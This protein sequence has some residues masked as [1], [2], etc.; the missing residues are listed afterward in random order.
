M[1][2][3]GN[4][5]GQRWLAAVGDESAV[6]VIAQVISN[7]KLG[8]ARLHLAGR[9]GHPEM[10]EALLPQLSE[11]DPA[12]ACAAGQAF[13][14]I[15]GI[16][17]PGQRQAAPMSAGASDFERE[18]ADDIWLPDAAAARQHWERNAM[19]WRQGVRMC[20]GCEI[21]ATLDQ[22]AQQRIDLEAFWDFGARAALNGQR[23]FAPP[24]V[25]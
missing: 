12:T 20:R 3:S 24:A 6:T 23:L 14:R 17:L 19:R 10:I 1:A 11:S 25:V 22:E 5:V 15:T 7:E 9:H 18:F 8:P 4:A 16:D 2:E 21:S 13:T